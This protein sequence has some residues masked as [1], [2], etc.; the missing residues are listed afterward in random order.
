M[1][2][3]L[4]IISL[5]MFCTLAACDS[6]TTSTSIEVSQESSSVE[7][8]NNV[9]HFPDGGGIKFSNPYIEKKESPNVHHK[10]FIVDS[11]M[12]SFKALIK[13]V[14]EDQGYELQGEIDAQDFEQS[15]SFAKAGSVKRVNYRMKTTSTVKGERILVRVSWA[16]K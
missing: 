11:N 16:L 6:N 12:D 10:T 7:P 8:S 13:E 4:K 2:K 5:F 1:K 9:V 3:R 15:L 14:M